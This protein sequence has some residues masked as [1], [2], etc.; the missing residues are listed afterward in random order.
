MNQNTGSNTSEP[1]KRCQFCT[2]THWLTECPQFIKKSPSE[3][4]LCFKGEGR[5]FLCHKKYHRS[6]ECITKKRCT[7]EGCGKR[8]SFLLHGVFKSKARAEY[9]GESPKV[10]TTRLKSNIVYLQTLPI[11]LHTPSGRVVDTFAMLDSGSQATLVRSSFAKDIGLNGPTAS[12]SIG[13]I[14]ENEPVQQSKRVT[15]WL[16][17]PEDP[18]MNPIKVN[19]A[20]TFNAPFNLPQQSIPCYNEGGSVWTH[21]RDLNLSPIDTSQITVLIGA[22]TKRAFLPLEVREGPDDQPMAIRTP[23][24]WTLMGLAAEIPENYRSNEENPSVNSIYVDHEDL[25]NQVEKFWRTDTFGTIAM[26][27]NSYSMNDLK[28]QEHLDST[29]RHTPSGHYEVGML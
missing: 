5:C 27:R 1:V 19:N 3:K 13:N 12:L 2:G 9:S 16:T 10:A 17:N 8:H 11:R 28:A 7:V 14:R 23:L 22:D 6:A 21:T 20:W 29:L 15:F 26:P 18:N 4:L 25:Q 24:G